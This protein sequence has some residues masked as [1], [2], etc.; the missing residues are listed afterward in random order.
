[1]YAIKNREG[2]IDYILRS[3]VPTS[4]TH[5]AKIEAKEEETEEE[6]E[7]KHEPAVKEKEEEEEEGEEE[8]K[9]SNVNAEDVLP[10]S[11]LL[12][13]QTNVKVPTCEAF[14]SAANP[15]GSDG[16]CAHCFNQDDAC[17]AL[18][19]GKFLCFLTYTQYNGE[20][21]EEKE[22]LMEH[23]R[24]TYHAV[25]EWD[26]CVHFLNGRPYPIDAEEVSEDVPKCLH[27]YRELWMQKLQERSSNSI[28]DLKT[29][30]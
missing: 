27:R 29:C 10:D 12:T 2:E 1:M 26:K 15:P 23:F 11:N 21:E 19:Y 16:L 18:K 20:I 13:Q 7:A 24:T 25:C 17:H 4:S 14:A 30:K 8:A 9:E 22:K 5:Q 28:I 3:G 6:L